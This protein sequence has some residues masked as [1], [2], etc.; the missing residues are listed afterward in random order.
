[1]TYS[2]L[3]YT[4]QIQKNWKQMGM[5]ELFV[6]IERGGGRGWKIILS[7]PILVWEEKGK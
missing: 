6:V 3:M 1:M 7:L 5:K 2:K 4:A